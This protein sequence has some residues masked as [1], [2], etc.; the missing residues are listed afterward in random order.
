MKHLKIKIVD[1]WHPFK[2][3]VGP[4]HPQAEL[5]QG[6]K[7]WTYTIEDI[8]NKHRYNVDTSRHPYASLQT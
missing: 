5:E 1:H 8:S 7:K 4:R 6:Q 2:S 3:G